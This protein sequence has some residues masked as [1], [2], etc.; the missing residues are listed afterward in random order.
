MDA[1]DKVS[2]LETLFSAL[3]GL[4]VLVLKMYNNCMNVRLCP[5]L[6]SVDLKAGAGAQT[7]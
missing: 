5:S 2:F 3:E 1:G 6:L 7:S 4:Q